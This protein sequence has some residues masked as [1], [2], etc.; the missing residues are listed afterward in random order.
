MGLWK[1]CT[2]VRFDCVLARAI[3]VWKNGSVAEK[4]FVVFVD[5]G[6]D[7]RDGNLVN[8]LIP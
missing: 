5:D 7:T 1:F 4:H 6:V 2:Y 8:D 3:S